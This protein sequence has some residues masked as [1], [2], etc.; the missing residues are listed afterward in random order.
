MS[1][2]AEYVVREKPHH[3]ALEDYAHIIWDRYLIGQ[4]AEARSLFNQ[5]PVDR[6]GYVA[7][8]ITAYSMSRHQLT[9]EYLEAFFRSV[10][11]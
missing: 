2:I 10:M 7:F 8:H 9:K 3:R 6:R 5:A 1:H 11:E 4:K